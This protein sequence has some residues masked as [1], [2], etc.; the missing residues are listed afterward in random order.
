MTELQ[1]EG[2]VDGGRDEPC[3]MPRNWAKC[4]DIFAARWATL[5]DENL[6]ILWG[7][8]SRRQVDHQE[9]AQILRTG[10]VAIA[11]DRPTSETNVCSGA[12]I[13]EMTFRCLG[14]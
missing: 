1:K 8:L 3:L 9:A 13:R 6:P 7:A 12:L 2:Q 11:A 10:V 4:R 14:A 5:V